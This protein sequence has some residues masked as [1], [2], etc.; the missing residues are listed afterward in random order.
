MGNFCREVLP[1]AADYVGVL[2]NYLGN[3]RF[4]GHWNSNILMNMLDKNVI[5]ILMHL[6]IH[7]RCVIH[8]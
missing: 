1:G 2:A 3:D 4:G 5:S 7:L 8:S 6:E